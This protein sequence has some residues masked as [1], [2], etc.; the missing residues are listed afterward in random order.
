M[1][2]YTTHEHPF[3]SFAGCPCPR[4]QTIKGSVGHGKE[5]HKLYLRCASL[6]VSEGLLIYLGLVLNLQAYDGTQPAMP[7]SQ[8]AT[9]PRGWNN[10]PTASVPF[11][12]S[13]PAGL[14]HAMPQSSGMYCVDDCGFQ[15]QNLDFI[16][17]MWISQSGCDMNAMIAVH[18]WR[19][20]GRDHPCLLAQPFFIFVSRPCCCDPQLVMP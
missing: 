12:V 13:T 9:P 7:N 14:S 16:V 1:L 8:R 3:H 20:V 18:M 10:P 11:L 17:R 6:R 19:L 15:C 4:Q 5:L 2:A